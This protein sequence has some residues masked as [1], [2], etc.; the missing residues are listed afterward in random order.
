LTLLA[1]PAIA[2]YRWRTQ[3]GWGGN[4]HAL[5]RCR[6]GSSLRYSLAEAHHRVTSL[7]AVG[8]AAVLLVGGATAAVAAAPLAGASGADAVIAN[9]PSEGYDAWATGRLRH[10]RL[11]AIW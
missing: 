6:R 10:R 9:L 5:P 11:S 2:G 4:G 8:V 3:P 7:K 1:E